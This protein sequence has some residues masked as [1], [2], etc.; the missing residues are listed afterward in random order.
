MHI[1][2]I[3]LLKHKSIKCIVHEDH[4]YYWNT[5]KIAEKTPPNVSLVVETQ[6]IK[7]DISSFI[8][9]SIDIL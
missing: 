8:L 2:I 6:D 5:Y 1:N 7:I 9:I 3:E 4:Y